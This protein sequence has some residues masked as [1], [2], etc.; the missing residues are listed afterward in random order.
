MKS[1]SLF[2]RILL[3]I[4]A[5]SSL[6]FDV[7]GKKLTDRIAKI[8]RNFE[9]GFRTKMRNI[10][11]PTKLFIIFNLVNSYLKYQAIK[12]S[13]QYDYQPH[14]GMPPRKN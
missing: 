2:I 13:V 4:F 9:R 11:D 10:D 3:F 14:Y 5:I 12:F 6:I 8:A 1:N 7:S